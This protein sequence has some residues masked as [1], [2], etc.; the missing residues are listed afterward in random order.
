MSNSADNSKKAADEEKQI[1][2]VNV[3]RRLR[4]AGFANHDKCRKQETWNFV[5][6]LSHRT[7]VDVSHL[8]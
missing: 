3:K 6:K 2:K 7:K 4:K 5:R 1:V 8:T